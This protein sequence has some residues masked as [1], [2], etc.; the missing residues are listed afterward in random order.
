MNKELELI[1]EEARKS[2]P[3]FEQ[4]A[5]MSF[6]RSVNATMA[7]KDISRQELANRMGTS[8]GYITRIMSG[9][10]KLNLE[11]MVKMAYVMDMEL[12]IEVVYPAR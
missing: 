10:I 9:N 7:L 8:K 1:N 3:Y 5:L 6:T 2:F 4:G 11:T 12:K